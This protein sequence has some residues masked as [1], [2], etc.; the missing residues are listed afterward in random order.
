MPSQ[1]SEAGFQSQVVELARL[2]GWL[3]QHTRPAKV[4]D[5]WLTPIQGQP[6]FPDLV[7]AH[8]RRGVL[9]AELKT[10]KGRLSPAQRLWRDTLIDAGASWHLWRPADLPTIA[11]VLG[12]L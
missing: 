4:G 10:E 8:H 9:F 2:H 6:G 12:A 7:L 5:R 1:I 3:V 11:K